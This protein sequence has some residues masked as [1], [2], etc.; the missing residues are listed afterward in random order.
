MLCSRGPEIA[1]RLRDTAFDDTAERLEDGYDRET[2]VLALT[3]PALEAIFRV[4]EDCP[5][6]LAELRAVLLR[7]HECRRRE[8]LV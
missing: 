8:R 4:L 7:E 5:V 2:K 6:E 3:I 1:R